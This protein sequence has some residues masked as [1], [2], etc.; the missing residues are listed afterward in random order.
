MHKNF[1]Q[2]PPPF[3][4]YKK[5]I[6]VQLHGCETRNL[7]EL[8]SRDTPISNEMVKVSFI[9]GYKITHKVIN[10]K[11]NHNIIYD[12][13]EMLSKWTHSSKCIE[14][15]VKSQNGGLMGKLR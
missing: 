5:I 11:I 12:C 9:Y 4:L 7:F 8:L 1:L 3:F 14:N 2:V 6:D 10:D 13:N 15:K